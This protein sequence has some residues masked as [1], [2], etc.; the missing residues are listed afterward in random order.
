M[1]RIAF[2]LEPALGGGFHFGREG[3]E[4]EA[5][6]EGLPS[7]SL[8]GALVVAYRHL[9]GDVQEFLAPWETG[10]PPFLLSSVFPYAGDLPLLPIPACRFSSSRLIRLRSRSSSPSNMYHRASFNGSCTKRRATVLAGWTAV[11]HPTWR[12][13]AGRRGTD[14]AAQTV[15][16]A[17][18]ARAAST[19]GMDGFCCAACQRGSHHFRRQQSFTSAAQPCR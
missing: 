1:E 17:G 15:S 2:R 6:S 16:P 10:T 14:L 11:W 13:L 12:C 5:S 19:A 4:I 18:A 9:F 3:R 8:F 7:D